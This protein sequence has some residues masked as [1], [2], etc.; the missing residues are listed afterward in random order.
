[1]GR[2]LKR[3]ESKKIKL[4]LNGKTYQAR[5]HNVNYDPRHN[6][7][8]DTLQI[9]YS[10]GSDFANE[11]KRLFYRSYNYINN[12]RSIRDKGDRSMI[13]LPEEDREYITFYTTEY[14]DTYLVDAI[15]NNDYSEFKS[16][17][18]KMT[19]EDL[20]QDINYRYK[21]NNPY[22]EETPGIL[23]VRKLNR[24]IG[25][26]LKLLYEFRCQ[27]CGEKIGNP[28]D[29]KVV[30]AHHIDYFV[31]SLNNDFD[32]QMIVCPNHHRIIHQA[33][34]VFDKK[35]KLYIY[36]NGMREGLILNVHL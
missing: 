27:I 10:S 28:Y 20:E 19:E 18:K 13:R 21:D 34:P 22:I 33:N 36:P 16:S 17:L 3:G 35:R 11:L 12:I 29:T 2:F 32:N 1:M 4:I 23:K 26:N 8:K 15:T 6:R 25:E 31:E 24:K 30:E 5:I 9:R 14:E 7:I